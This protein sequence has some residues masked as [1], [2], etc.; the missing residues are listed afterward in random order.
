MCRRKKKYEKIYLSEIG[1]VR[2]DFDMVKEKTIYG[3]LSYYKIKDKN[4]NNLESELKFDSYKK[5]KKYVC[6]KYDSYDK[7][8]LQEFYR[9]LNLKSRNVKFSDTYWGIFIPALVALNL[10]IWFELCVEAILTTNMENMITIIGLLWTTMFTIIVRSFWLVFIVGICLFLI[11]NFIEP[12]F[13]ND[14]ETYLLMDYMEIIKEII[15]NK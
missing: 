2:Y 9:F 3:Y 15:E 10:N 12:L 7:E 1:R 13:K 8:K 4:I 14:L 5:W 11:K 6:D